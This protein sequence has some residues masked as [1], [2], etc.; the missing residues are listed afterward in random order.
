[1]SQA[2]SGDNDAASK[3]SAL[4]SI[5]GK[6]PIGGGD[7]KVQEGEELQAA[8]K[9][10]NFDP[11]NIAPPEVQQKLVQLLKWHDGLMRDILKKIEMIPGLDEL[12]DELSNALNACK[13]VKCLPPPF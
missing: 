5:L 10:Y 1:M 2:Q 7:S 8:S 9:A 12:V 3:I 13:I 6:L 11:D 4:K